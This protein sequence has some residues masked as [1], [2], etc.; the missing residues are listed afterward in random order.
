MAEK[1][2]NMLKAYKQQNRDNVNICSAMLSPHDTQIDKTE[3]ELNKNN[4]KKERAVNPLAIRP[5]GAHVTLTEEKPKVSIIKN[6][7]G[8]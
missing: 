7:F 1:N 2:Q 6:L 5:S 4:E 8:F 3:K